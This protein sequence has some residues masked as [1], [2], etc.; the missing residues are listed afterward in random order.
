[1]GVTLFGMGRHSI[2]VDHSIKPLK[3]MDWT[4]QSI[5]EVNLIYGFTLFSEGFRVCQ[6][7]V[8]VCYDIGR[9]FKDVGRICRDVCRVCNAGC[10]LCE[11][12]F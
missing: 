11:L 10:Q 7:I 8:T 2:Y 5:W 12:K 4:G 6:D 1:M 3:P 9:A